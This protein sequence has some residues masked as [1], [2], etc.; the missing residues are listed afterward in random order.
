MV[1][2]IS[3]EVTLI[4][5]MTSATLFTTLSTPRNQSLPLVSIT[6]SKVSLVKHFSAIMNHSFCLAWGFLFSKEVRDAKVANLALR[7]QRAALAW[8]QE[9]IVGFGGDPS[10]VTIWGESA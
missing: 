3:S 8:I 6:V 4:R 1:G 5:D 10:K 9:N 7:D 2:T